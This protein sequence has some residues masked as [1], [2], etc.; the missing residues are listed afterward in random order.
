[1]SGEAPT[2]PARKSSLNSWGVLNVRPCE[3]SVQAM[4]S[5]YCPVMASKSLRL[6][7]S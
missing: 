1:M 7:A 2:H 6:K 5:A 3:W 4:L